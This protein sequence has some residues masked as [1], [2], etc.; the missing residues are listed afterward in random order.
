MSV[1]SA[2]FNIWRFG[3]KLTMTHGSVSFPRRN[4][5]IRPNATPPTDIPSSKPYS[6]PAGLIGLEA[7][8]FPTM[9]TSQVLIF[10]KAAVGMEQTIKVSQTLTAPKLLIDQLSNRLE[11]RQVR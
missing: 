11:Y 8:A 9:C 6:Y 3:G 1:R 7:N 2:V 10:L 5:T 4:I